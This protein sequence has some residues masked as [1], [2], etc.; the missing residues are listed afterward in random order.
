MAGA[1]LEATGRPDTGQFP[2][3]QTQIRSADMHEQSLEHVGMAAQ[4]QAPQSSRFVE[5][6]VRTLESFTALAQQAPPARAPNASPVGVNGCPGRGLSSPAPPSPV[7]LGHVTADPQL[8]QRHQ[9]LVAVMALVTHHLD[10][11]GSVQQD[12]LDLLCGGDQRLDHRLCVAG[13]GILHRDADDR[14]GFQVDRVLGLVRQT[15]PAV[16]T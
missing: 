10:E 2:H 14:A 6:G 15:R 5:M 3:E 16:F 7:R 12:R 1:A 9:G 4:M 8:G 11:A 13:I